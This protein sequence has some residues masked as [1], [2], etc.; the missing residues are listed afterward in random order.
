MEVSLA[1]VYERHRWAAQPADPTLADT[2]SGPLSGVATLRFK[3]RRKS[4]RLW[5]I[6]NLIKVYLAGGALAQT[7]QF[8]VAVKANDLI[9]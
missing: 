3:T 4:E 2:N 1:G 8:A 5:M 6:N 7:T 9:C